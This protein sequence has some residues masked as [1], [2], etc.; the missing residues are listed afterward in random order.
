M[1]INQQD[2]IVSELGEPRFES[3]LGLSKVDGDYLTNYV[4]NDERVLYNVSWNSVQ[5][6]LQENRQPIT[7][8]R[9]GPREKIFFEPSKTKIGIVT[10]GGLCPGINDV[11][12]ALVMQHSWWYGIKTIYGFRYGYQGMVK[13]FKL[14]PIVLDPEMVSE[15]HERGGTMLGSSRGPQDVSSRGRT[16]TRGA[17]ARSGTPRRA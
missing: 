1:E 17:L 7:F 6:C 12:R 9:A 11:I 3:P 4:P 14:N 5:K 15:I 13:E 16:R 8:E 2:F 10:C